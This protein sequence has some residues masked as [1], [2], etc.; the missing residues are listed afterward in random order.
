MTKSIEEICPRVNTTEICRDKCNVDLNE[1]RYFEVTTDFKNLPNSRELKCYMHCFMLACEIFKPDSPR[2][3]TVQIME[4]MEKLPKYAQDILFG[5]GR[6]CIRRIV[7]LRD[8][9]EVAY[10]LNVCSKENDNEVGAYVQSIRVVAVIFQ[11]HNNLFI[12]LSRF[13]HYFFYY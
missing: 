8:P 7:H 2:L 13:Q 6:G 1:V 11:I 5:M 10:T 4:Q 9:Y 12:F 3:N